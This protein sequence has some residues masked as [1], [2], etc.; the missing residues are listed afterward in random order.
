MNKRQE[1]ALEKIG[2]LFN[3]P[4]KDERGGYALGV[5]EMGRIH[6][7]NIKWALYDADKN[8]YGFS[9]DTCEATKDALR[10]FKK[11][12]M[13]ERAEV[14]DHHCTPRDDTERQ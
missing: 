2:H 1:E 13:E 5:F 14:I 6:N 9:Y 8:E 3:R 11:L 7:T 4:N 10:A 12:T